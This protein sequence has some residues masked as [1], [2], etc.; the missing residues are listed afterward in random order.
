V[1]LVSAQKF[2]KG[3]L[4]Y[5]NNKI[6]VGLIDIP[7]TPGAKKIKFK[8]NESSEPLKIK[9]DSIRLITITSDE[10][11]T[12]TLENIEISRKEKAF[13]IVIVKGYS[14]LYLTG[15]GISTDKHGN[16]SPTAI[17]VSGRS[18]PEFYYLIKRKNE[19]YLTTIAITSPSKTMFGKAK[20]FRK[21]AAEYF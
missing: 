20:A 14:C 4:T 12:C 10:G 11:I 17:F 9:S 8:H 15:Q 13:C 6:L 1:N 18:M 16:V 2:F 21:Q 19:K 7:D 3:Q 5:K